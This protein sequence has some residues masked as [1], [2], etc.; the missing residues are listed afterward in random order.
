MNHYF[1]PS[2]NLGHKE[3]EIE[4]IHKFTTFYFITDTGVFSKDKVDSATDILL[5]NLPV[6]SGEVLDLGCG[7]GCAGIALAKIYGENISVT[8]SDI[9]RRAVDLAIKNAKKN[10]VAVKAVCSDGF[11]NIS[12]HFGAIIFNPPIHAGKE[13]VYKMYE[14]AYIHLETGGRFF[15]V[16]QKKHGAKSHR[17][18]LE[19]IFK[20]ENS[21]VAYSKKGFFVFEFKKI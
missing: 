20:A 16:I 15:I 3:K 4:Y 7:Y 9:N 21:C 2:E 6:L 19:T 13:A 5:N 11:T 12:E 10:G 8:M 18:K 14:D 1:N 17:Q